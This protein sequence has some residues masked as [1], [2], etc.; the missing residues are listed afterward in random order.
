ML[1][2]PQKIVACVAATASATWP[3]SNLASGTMALP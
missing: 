1:G 2:T 3:G